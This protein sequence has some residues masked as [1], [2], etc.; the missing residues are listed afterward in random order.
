MVGYVRG[1]SGQEMIAYLKRHCPHGITNVRIAELAGVSPATVNTW[2][3]GGRPRYDNLMRL[4]QALPAH[5][6]LSATDPDEILRLAG[7]GDSVVRTPEPVPL[8][9]GM[10][11]DL[12]PEHEELIWRLPFPLAERAALVQAQRDWR[13]RHP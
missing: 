11:L 12:V 10:D 4:I 3:K 13:Q 6:W 5:E 8:P 1:V 9:E 7:Y 2:Q